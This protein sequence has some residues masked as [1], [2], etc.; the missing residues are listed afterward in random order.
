MDTHEKYVT[1]LLTNKCNINSIFRSLMLC[2]K[3]EDYLQYNNDQ[4]YSN[5]RQWHTSTPTMLEGV[6]SGIDI[7]YSSL[8]I[9][10]S[11]IPG[12]Y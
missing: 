2:T 1:I 11:Q 8:A 9:S 5:S 6:Y 12:R 10:V 3:L 4:F 7:L